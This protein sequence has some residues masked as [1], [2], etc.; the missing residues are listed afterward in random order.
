MPQAIIQPILQTLTICLPGFM[1]IHRSDIFGKLRYIC[2]R[3][4][5]ASAAKIPG[6]LA[7]FR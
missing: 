1:K 6:S 5:V 4:M 3:G 2:P 7:S